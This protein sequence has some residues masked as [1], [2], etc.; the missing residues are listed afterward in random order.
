MVGK[1]FHNEKLAI[2]QE[3]EEGTAERNHT[4]DYPVI[5]KDQVDS[6]SWIATIT[7]QTSTRTAYSTQNR[8]KSL[9]SYINQIDAAVRGE[10]IVVLSGGWF[11]AGESTVGKLCLSLESH[12]SNLV[13]ES[14]HVRVISLG[15]DGSP[16]ADGYCPLPPNLARLPGRVA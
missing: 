12:L 1:K 2:K 7:L 8:L 4:T 11:D 3:P 10:G 15:V 6:S 16:D 5:H 9:S 14:D 13:T